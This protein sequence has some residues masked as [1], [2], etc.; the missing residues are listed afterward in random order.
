QNLIL[1][2]LLRH[3]TVALERELYVVGRDRLAVMESCPL[4]EHELVDQPVRETLHDSARLGALALPAIDLT[5]PSCRAKRTIRGVMMT[6]VSA[7][8]NQ[9]GAIEAPTA[10]VS[11]SPGPATVGAAGMTEIRRRSVPVARK[12]TVLI[13]GASLGARKATG[14]APR[15]APRL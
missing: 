11:W 14:D 8:S 10:Q 5:R 3:P 12:R 15:I 1:E 6:E 9:V 2:I 7:G 13:I 4:A